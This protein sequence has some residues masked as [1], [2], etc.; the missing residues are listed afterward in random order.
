MYENIITQLTETFK[1]DFELVQDDLGALEHTVKQKIQLLGH[2]LLQRL[3]NQQ[4]NGYHGSSIFCQ[5]GGSMKFMQHRERNVHTIFGWIKINR[6]YYHCSGCGTGLAPYDKASGLGAE[7]LSPGLAKACC[8]LAVDNSFEQVS[9]KIEQFFGQRVCDDTVNQVVHRAGSVVLKEQNQELELF[10]TKRQIPQAQANP[11]RLYISVDGTTVHEN[12]AWHEVK[13]GC[14]Y[15]TNERFERIER[16]VGRFDDSQVFGWHLWLEGCRCGLREAKEVV[17][18]GDGAGWIRSEHHRHFGRATFIIDWYHASE[19]IWDCGK[20]IFG[21]GSGEAH[22]WV[23]KCQDFL[24]GGWTK[25]LLDDLKEQRKKYRGNK[26]EAL[27]TLIRYISTNEERMRYDVF[28]SKGYDI[29]SGKVEAA[30]KNVVGKRLKQ[31]G[32]IWSRA[33][34]SATLALRVTWLNDR[35]E[36]LWQN[37][38]LAA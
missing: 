9:K 23:K 29:G 22:R 16:Y 33:G 31:S 12:D 28:R 38:P 36:Q 14:I 8:L 5:C 17:Y 15:W 21:E 3:V 2:G 37:K 25:R 6:A 24:W 20:A 35:W 10:F 11:E 30:C 19:H 1:E 32:M 26:R 27:E 13:V 4:T 18:I 34:S 7:Q